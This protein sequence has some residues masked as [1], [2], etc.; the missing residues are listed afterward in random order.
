MKSNGRNLI[1][2]SAKFGLKFDTIFDKFGANS[3]AKMIKFNAQIYK[4]KA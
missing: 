2:K 4:E 3:D 1:V